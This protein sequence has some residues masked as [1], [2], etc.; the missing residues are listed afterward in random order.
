MSTKRG[1]PDDAA[2]DP[3][4]V[5]GDGGYGSQASGSADD[6]PRAPYYSEI[7]CVV[8]RFAWIK[9]GVQL[10]ERQGPQNVCWVACR[11]THG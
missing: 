5:V 4:W 10:L 9:H 11:E 3:G 2:V 8:Y 1:R 6:S 7:Q